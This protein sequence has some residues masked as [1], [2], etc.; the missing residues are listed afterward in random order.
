[1]RI[2]KFIAHAGYCSRREAEKLIIQ[3]FV[4]INDIIIHELFTMVYEKDIVFVEGNKLSLPSKTRLWIYYKPYGLITTHFDPQGRDTV[5]FA[6][7]QALQAQD[8]KIK[9][10]NYYKKHHEKLKNASYED[11][12]FISHNDDNDQ[13]SHHQ[14]HLISVGRLD[15]NSEG[16][17]LITNNG[18]LARKLEK[19][20]LPRKY[21]CRVDGK[22]SKEQIIDAKA[23]LTIDGIHYRE[24][25]IQNEKIQ[26]KSKTTI[27]N[28]LRNSFSRNKWVTIT[29][30]E[31][32]N[33]EIRNIMSY[34]NLEVSRLIRISYGN[35]YLDNLNPND[36][37]EVDYSLFEQYL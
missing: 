37:I 30:Y 18:D 20:E 24:I 29:L 11:K 21:R 7:K 2:A 33:R 36:I 14:Q 12:S 1:M 3:G 35:F 32:K 5:F 26:D 25:E 6:V 15:I 4:K 34:F 8:Q 17:L 9:Q 23:G 13:K 19:S 10:T 31:G 28:S 27:T 22:I 16:L